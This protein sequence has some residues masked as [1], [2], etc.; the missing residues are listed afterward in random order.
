MKARPVSGQSGAPGEFVLHLPLAPRPQ[1]GD[2]NAGQ[3][4]RPDASLAS[5]GTG[6]TCRPRPQRSPCGRSIRA[7]TA[8]LDLSRNTVRRFAR[9]ASPEELLVR[10]GT[11]RRPSIL[12]EHTAY[13]RER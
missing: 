9:A 1:G 11:G 10:D 12:D 8:A 2:H 4:H 6:S 7:I 5:P 3:W 13:L